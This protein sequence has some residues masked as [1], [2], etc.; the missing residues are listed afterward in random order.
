VRG[1]KR[2]GTGDEGGRRE[3]R[4]GRGKDDSWYLGGSTPLAVIRTLI[5]L[6]A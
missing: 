4:K 2:E 3:G 1:R 6:A 5:V